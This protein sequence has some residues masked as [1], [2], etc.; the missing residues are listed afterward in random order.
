M[1]VKMKKYLLIILVCCICISGCT[2]EKPDAEK[3]Q[4]KQTKEALAEAN[5]QIGMPAIKNFQE[6][7]LLH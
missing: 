7:K 5:A 6:R 2:E 4:A 3:I 1:E